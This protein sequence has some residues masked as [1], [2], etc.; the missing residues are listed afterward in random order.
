[1]K[2]YDLPVAKGCRGV[3]RVHLPPYH[4]VGVPRGSQRFKMECK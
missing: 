4:V 1:M 2:R 3:G